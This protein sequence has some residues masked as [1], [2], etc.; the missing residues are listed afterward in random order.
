VRRNVGGWIA[1][2]FSIA[3]AGATPALSGCR[4]RLDR[5]PCGDTAS[6][7]GDG[8]TVD[9]AGCDPYS[10]T[11][12]PEP[13]APEPPNPTSVRRPFLV[14][15]SLRHA[16]ADAREDWLNHFDAALELDA[17]ARAALAAAWLADGLEEHASVAAF[18]RFSL[19]ALRVG[20]PPELIADAQRAS[21]D[22]IRHA[23]VCFGLARRYGAAEAG[24]GP[25][26]VD[27]ALA[28]LSLA[29]LAALTAEEGCLGET[30]GALQA[31]RQAALAAPPIKQALAGIA[32][33]EERHAELAWRFV[34]WACRSG[35]AA[36][37]ER[38]AAS[39]EHAAAATR[40]MVVRPLAVDAAAWHA[41]GR[42]SCA[43]AHAIADEGLARVVLPALDALRGRAHAA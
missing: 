19:M 8:A 42:L 34:A 6:A 35:G 13:P 20:A 1:R 33:D 23:R 21:L 40:A 43:E 31:E 11:P 2:I 3:A 14:G 28:P 22:E 7:P 37:V 30:L 39:I 5:P 24:P 4:T 9:L 36:I 12:P 29:E 26:R 27:D 10:E 25:L 32:R 15:G 18:A 41:H 17:Q 38:V 16:A